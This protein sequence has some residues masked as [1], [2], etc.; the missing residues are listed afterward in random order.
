MAERIEGAVLERECG[1]VRRNYLTS[2]GKA[3]RD[4]ALARDPQR[5]EWNV[6][7]YN[8]ATRELR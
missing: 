6:Y 2:S 7:D 8:V 1:G 5:C 4:G 3:V